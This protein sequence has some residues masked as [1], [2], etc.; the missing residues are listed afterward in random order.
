MSSDGDVELNTVGG[1][2]SSSGPTSPSAAT[3]SPATSSGAHIPHDRHRPS[4]STHQRMGMGRDREGSEVLFHGF[5]LSALA[6]GAL[7]TGAWK[8]ITANDLDEEDEVAATSNE[9]RHSTSDDNTI[10][11]HY[12]VNHGA[13]IA[14]VSNVTPPRR[15]ESPLVTDG[16]SDDHTHPPTT[17]HTTTTPNNNNNNNNKRI[18]RLESDADGFDNATRPMSLSR[19]TLNTQEQENGPPDNSL[20]DPAQV[21]SLSLS[22]SLS[23]TLHSLTNV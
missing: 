1:G 20:Y 16:T 5:G 12:H 14:A 8:P 9:P 6:M 7:S 21:Y 18:V 17:T 19:T 15:P 13:A 10:D 11:H 2:T 4:L 23:V 3:T 22:F